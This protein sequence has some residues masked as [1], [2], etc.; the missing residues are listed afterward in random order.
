M[1]EA[2]A[3]VTKV[4]LPTPAL[5]A[6]YAF[7]QSPEDT[8]FASQFQNGLIPILVQPHRGAPKNSP[9]LKVWTPGLDQTQRPVR[10]LSWR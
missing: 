8:L 3:W 4:V 6:E 7:E 10:R 5:S 2:G 1:G 9:S